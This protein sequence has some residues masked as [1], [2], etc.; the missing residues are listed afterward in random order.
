MLK[1]RRTLA[2]VQMND[3]EA[4]NKHSINRVKKKINDY[5]LNNY[6]TLFREK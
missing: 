5:I 3:E 4:F 6:Q 1:Q 2:D